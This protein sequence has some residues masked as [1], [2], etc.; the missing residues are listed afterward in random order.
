[1][2]AQADITHLHKHTPAHS[3]T[4]LYTFTYT[5]LLCYRYCL[6]MHVT[7]SHVALM[8]KKCTWTRKMYYNGG[9]IL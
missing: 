7:L 4:G 2:L 5:R 1:M 8:Y 6:V 3:E 9:S